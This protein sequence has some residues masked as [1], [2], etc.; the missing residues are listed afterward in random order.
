MKK[1]LL[2][3]F[4]L[5]LSFNSYGEWVGSA[6]DANGNIHYLDFEDMKKTDGYIY[7]W[8]MTNYAN[9][10]DRFLSIATYREADCDLHRFKDL[11]FNG[12]TQ[13]MAEGEPETIDLTKLEEDWDYPVANTFGDI[14]LSLVCQGDTSIEDSYGD[15][16]EVSTHVDGSSSFYMDPD[17]VKERN[18]YISFWTL[19]DYLDDSSENILSQISRRHV[20]CE[21]GKLRNESVYSYDDNMGE[22]EVTIPD[23]VTISEWMTPPPGS[24]YDGYIQFGCGINKLSDEELE[25]I[26]IEWRAEMEETP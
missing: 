9:P 25:E 6:V 3:L 10:T 22:G 23:E 13:E 15:W 16:Y 12:Y 8:E 20:N 24:N 1:L 26:K 5:M 2:L 21:E 11:T 14:S 18:G 19:I 7:Y 4:S 17:S